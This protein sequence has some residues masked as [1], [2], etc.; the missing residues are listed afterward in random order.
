MK[1]PWK[2]IVIL[3]YI[4]KYTWPAQS[5]NL[6]YKNTCLL[7][8]YFEQTYAS[9]SPV[10]SHIMRIRCYFDTTM[11]IYKHFAVFM[12][13][14]ATCVKQKMVTSDE[15]VEH[16][17]QVCFPSGLTLIEGFAN[18]NQQNITRM[19]Q[20]HLHILGMIDLATIAQIIHLLGGRITIAEKWNPRRTSSTVT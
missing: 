13:T 20:E 12:Y 18:W 6:T 1:K 5:K 2:G 15:D 7:F 16:R 8:K 19:F 14:I 11:L 17:V 3:F 9:I 4:H 10:N